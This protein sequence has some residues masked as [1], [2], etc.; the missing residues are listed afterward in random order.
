MPFNTDT[1]AR[2][3]AKFDKLSGDK[4][5]AD[6]AT[7][8]SNSADAAAVAANA[9][10]AQKTLAEQAADHLVTTDIADLAAEFDALVAEATPAPAVP[11]T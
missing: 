1:L 11:T 4:S 6:T 10:A 8:E 2:L 3:K 5:D 7:Q 9:L